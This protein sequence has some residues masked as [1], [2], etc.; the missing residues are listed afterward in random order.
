MA[1]LFMTVNNDFTQSS[2]LNP[3]IPDSEKTK[4]DKFSKVTDW[5]KLKNKQH[6][7]KVLP[8]NSHTLGFYPQNQKLENFVSPKVSPWESKGLKCSLETRRTEL[9]L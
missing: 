6:H 1:R 4:S 2:Y 3:F 5:E 9:R 8:M 7:S